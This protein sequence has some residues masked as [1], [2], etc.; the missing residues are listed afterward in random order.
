VGP[1]EQRQAPEHLN[2]GQVQH[3]NP[4]DQIMVGIGESPAH[5]QCD[6][7]WHGTRSDT[8]RIAVLDCL[9]YGVF[10]PQPVR[11]VLVRDREKG[12]MLAL[13]TTDL[14]VIGAGLV[15]R[16]PARWAIEV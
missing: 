15:T 14:G 12:P 6:G 4:H 2:H 10:G 11:M 5:R 3:P 16:Y 1:G 13:V 8:V 9:W 7:F